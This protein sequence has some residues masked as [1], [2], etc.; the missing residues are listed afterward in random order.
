[1][2]SG[3]GNVRL[4]NFARQM[5]I[6]EKKYRWKLLLIAAALLIVV[7]SLW[8]TNKLASKI[9]AEEK[10][11]VELI[12]D[13]Y[14]R[15]NRSTPESD[16]SYL[17]MVITSN[18]TV[19]IILTDTEDQ[20]VGFKN[21]DSLKS[22]NNPKYLIK[23]LESMRAANERIHIYVT[24]E[25]SNY[26]Y[27]K[28][29]FLLTQLR[30]YP[31]VQFG[32]IGIF[33]FTSYIAFSISRKAEQNQVWVGM[34]KETAHQ[35]GTPLSSLNAWLELLEEKKMGSEADKYLS[36]MNKDVSRLELISERFSKIGSAPD[37][38]E[39]NMER[40]IQKTV[41]YYRQRSSNKVNYTVEVTE[42]N[43]VSRINPSLFDWVIENLL[44][45]ALDA[46][47]GSGDIKIK[48]SQNVSQIYVDVVDSGK[49]I[50]KSRFK[51]VFQPGF[52]TKTRGWGLGLSLSKRI[53][54]NYHNGRIFVKDSGSDR[55][56]T[57]RIALPA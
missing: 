42:Q 44:K 15:V 11:K 5:N 32:I 50:P 6:Y 30:Y 41:E 1:M 33:L 27:Y 53:I 16:M 28:D 2:K 25:I 47:E 9:A 54:E 20:I 52:S 40:E 46:M 8:Y 35:L 45:N 51:T 14:K 19:P 23:E 12:A 17:Q 4:F 56:T 36:E 18:E 57:F 55:G 43:I 13:A 3:I 26:I 7:A 34:A 21:L 37:L 29:S 38:K 48:I 31:W 24:D 10:R 49:G 22:V 39:I